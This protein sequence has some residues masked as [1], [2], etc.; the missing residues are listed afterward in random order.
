MKRLEWFDYTFG[1]DISSGFIVYDLKMKIGPCHTYNTIIAMN[2]VTANY[3][4]PR[5]LPHLCFKSRTI[6]K[7]TFLDLK[8]ISL[9]K[10]L[11]TT[12]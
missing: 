3:L 5:Y 10:V 6:S 11:V 1:R 2:F 4:P 12:S 8:I 9:K 7:T